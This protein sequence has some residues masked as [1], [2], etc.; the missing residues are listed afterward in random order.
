MFDAWVFLA[1]QLGLGLIVLL[2]LNLYSIMVGASSLGKPNLW[3]IISDRLYF[4][5]LFSFNYI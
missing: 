1:G 3:F 5:L 2:Q 4:V